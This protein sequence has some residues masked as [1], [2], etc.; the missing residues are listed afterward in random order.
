MIRNCSLE[1]I[2]DGRLY[3]ENDLVKADT[4]NCEGCKSVC[5]HGMENTIIVE[6][7]DIYIMTKELGTTFDELLNG[8]LVINQVDGIMLPNLAMAAGTNSCS[9]LDDNK[10]CM[11]HK[12]RPA[13]CRLFP[14][15]R[16]WEDETHFKYILQ[17]GQCKKDNLAK[18]K[19][20]KWLD[21]DNL[22][23]YNKY[24]VL[25]HQYLKRIQAAVGDICQRAAAGELDSE[26]ATTQIKTI[27]LYTL[28]VFYRTDYVDDGTFFQ[29]FKLRIKNAYTALGMD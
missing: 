12:A 19:V 28:K 8:K 2:S 9:F 15:G 29:Q 10:R 18:I 16:Y 23:E 6:P 27:C 21:T 25:W 11:I 24:V 1:E 22:T 26:L 3:T 4:C 17:V 5:C 14:L 13:L 20:K 7:Y